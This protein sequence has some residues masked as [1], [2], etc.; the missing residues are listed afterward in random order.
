LLYFRQLSWV[1]LFVCLVWFGFCCCGEFFFLFFFFIRY[2][3]R[4]H[5]QCYPKSPPYPPLFFGFLFFWF[6][7][8]VLVFQDRVS[9]CSPGLAVL[10]LTLYVD[11]A[12]LEHRTRPASASQVLGLK[13]CATTAQQQLSELP[14]RCWESNL[15]PL[16]V[17]QPVLLTSEPS[18]QSLF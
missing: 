5:F 17:R 6:L 12:G 10:D 14:C 3:S 1:F 13:A 8:L 9:L 18:F 2:F 4:L 11:Q 16:E 15:G 7:V